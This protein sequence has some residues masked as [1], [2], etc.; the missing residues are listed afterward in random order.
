MSLKYNN[1]NE[2]VSSPEWKEFID[3]ENKA[4]EER[5]ANMTLKE[6]MAEAID[7]MVGPE[8]GKYNMIVSKEASVSSMIQ[9]F[10]D[11]YQKEV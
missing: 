8:P 10:L 1:I 2:I 6:R 11:K 3:L 4:A 9:K 7:K 5:M